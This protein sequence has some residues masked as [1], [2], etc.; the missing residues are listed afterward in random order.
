[1]AQADPGKD[2]FLRIQSI[3]WLSG[4]SAFHCFLKRSI[5]TYEAFYLKFTLKTVAAGDSVRTQLFSISI[6]Q[7]VRER[8]FGRTNN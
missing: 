7:S 5:Q 2:S 3:Y 8:N 4:D 1:M 6:L